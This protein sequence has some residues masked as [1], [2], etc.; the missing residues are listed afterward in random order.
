MSQRPRIQVTQTQRLALNLGLHAAIK[1]LR[2][3]AAG[4][5][6]YLEEQA[7]ENPYVKLDPP[8]LPAPGEW[9]PRWAQVFVP[10]DVVQQASAGP[11]LM[12]HVLAA[13][14]RRMTG[15]EERRVALALAEALEPSGWI[16]VPLAT[17]AD[18]LELPVAAVEA[19]LLRLQEIE[20]V[21]LFARDLAECLALQAQEEGSHDAVMAQ[22]LARLDL[23]AKGD[24]AGLAARI[25][26]PVAEVGLR[27]RLIRAMNPKPGTEFDGL[28]VA[29]PR[30]P[31][32]VVLRGEAGW[33][34]GLNR[35]SLPS[36]RIDA[37]AAGPGLGEARALQ[38]MVEARNS[39]L[40]RVGRAV[41]DRQ[42]RALDH[43]AGALVAMTMAEIAEAVQL[44]ESSV[45]RVV[46][47]TSVDTPH[48][49]WWLR[50]LFSRGL[51]TEQV[52]GA[53]LRDRLARL[54][55]A[56]PRAAPLSDEA[57]AEA[58]SREG[59]EVARRTVAK[60][61]SLLGIPPARR[62]RR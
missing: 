48:G 34:V 32:L 29:H 46:A 15:S 14:D 17:I 1:M 62:R 28:A 45:S 24:L 61:R 7:S 33:E 13:I 16:G 57:L 54:V 40:L 58:L 22:V 35:S 36:L 3:D 49:M 23:L 9:L 20:P 41:L 43:G 30:E 8:P 4:L 37:S 51:G 26:V 38:R 21:G 56:E 2:A 12:A 55:A 50:R 5:T 52:A 31:D 44:H 60:Y 10:G 39:T 25:G 53:A 11:S 18:A 27:F 6:R 47:G 42:V 59:A 19:V